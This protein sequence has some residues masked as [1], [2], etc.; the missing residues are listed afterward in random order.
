MEDIHWWHFSERALQSRVQYGGDVLQ[1]ILV[2][3]VHQCVAEAKAVCMRCTIFLAIPSRMA[4]GFVFLVSN[5]TR[6][7]R[8][9]VAL[10]VRLS[11]LTQ[12]LAHVQNN[13][14]IRANMATGTE[15]IITNRCY[16]D[17]DQDE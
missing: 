14:E 9:Q 13:N 5:C 8:L 2:H 3:Q 4:L 17:Q 16:Q 7:A 1:C 15:Q 6:T 12:C 11:R 10:H